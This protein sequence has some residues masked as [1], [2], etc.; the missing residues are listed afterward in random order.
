MTTRNW[1]IVISFRYF[2]KFFQNELFSLCRFYSNLSNLFGPLQYWDVFR[3]ENAWCM[4]VQ[5]NTASF[6]T[7]PTAKYIHHFTIFICGKTHFENNLK[8]V[9]IKLTFILS[10]WFFSRCCDMLA[11]LPPLKTTLPHQISSYL[12]LTKKRISNVF[13]KGIFGY[14]LRAPLRVDAYN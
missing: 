10:K 7:A 13:V 4:S 5:L 12:T 11:M 9:A 1:N 6:Y 2:Y 3:Y 8:T 14:L